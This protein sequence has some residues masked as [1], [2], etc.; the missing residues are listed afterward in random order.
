MP[1]DKA[2]PTPQRGADEPGAVMSRFDKD[3]QVHTWYREWREGKRRLS[4]CPI[5]PELYEVWLP[6][7]IL[8][9]VRKELPLPDFRVS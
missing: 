8:A 4:E 7:H 3:L 1:P 9:R 5:Y 2:L 6:P